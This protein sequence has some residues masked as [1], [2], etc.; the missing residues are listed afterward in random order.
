VFTSITTFSCSLPQYLVCGSPEQKLLFGITL[1]FKAGGFNQ[2]HNVSF[3]WVVNRF[4]NTV[5]TEAT[6]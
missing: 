5:P 1:L 2:S 6:I 3:K 4:N